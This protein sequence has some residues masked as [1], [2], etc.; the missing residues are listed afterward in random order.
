MENE[1]NIKR[2]MSSV[3]CVRFVWS[4]LEFCTVHKNQGYA[5]SKTVHLKYSWRSL[6]DFSFLALY[7]NVHAHMFN[8]VVLSENILCY[9]RVR[10]EHTTI[11]TVQSNSINEP[12]MK[13]QQRHE[14][15]NW[16]CFVCLPELVGCVYARERIDIHFIHTLNW[17]CS[18]FCEEC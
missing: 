2:T 13:Q 10:H 18:M 16:M 11:C 3:S 14:K 6:Y 12:T 7:N 8:T 9:Y 1:A 17:P 4:N 15:Y 5:I